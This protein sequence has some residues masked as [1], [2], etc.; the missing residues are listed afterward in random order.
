MPQLLGKGTAGGRQT[1]NNNAY[2]HEPVRLP[3][4]T[5]TT[6]YRRDEAINEEVQREHEGS[7]ATTPAE[8]VQNRGKE[9]REGV[10]D[11]VYQHHADGSNADNNPTVEKA[12]TS[13]HLQVFLLNSGQYGSIEAYLTIGSFY[14]APAWLILT[15]VGYQRQAHSNE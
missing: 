13:D 5:Q 10:P 15:D 7:A 8:L 14:L 12:W 11:A 9:D 1:E 2:R 3:A 6:G 4:V